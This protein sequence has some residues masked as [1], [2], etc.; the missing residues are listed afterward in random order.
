MRRGG[1]S[2]RRG[3][4]SGR[5]RFSLWVGLA[6]AMAVLVPAPAAVAADAEP[7]PD[8]DEGPSYLVPN[9]MAIGMSLTILAI[10]C[11]R[12]RKD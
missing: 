10:A 9:I 12:F 6:I 5:G 3:V 7:E 8:A 4:D 11:K 1:V 2:P